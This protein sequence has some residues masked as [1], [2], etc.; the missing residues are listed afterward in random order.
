[1]LTQGK[2]IV[3]TSPL[4]DCGKHP[5]A[6]IFPETIQHS[7]IAEALN[8]EV[9]S[10]GNVKVFG[11]KVQVYGES[12]TLGVRHNPDDVSVIEKA[13]SFEEYNGG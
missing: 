4:F 3:G 13:L 9:H 5:Q 1:M 11:H 2:Y 10:A 8:M 7:K 12:T 6:I